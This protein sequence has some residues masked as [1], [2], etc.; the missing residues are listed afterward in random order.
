MYSQLCNFDGLGTTNI[1]SGYITTSLGGTSD[2]L[3]STWYGLG[4]TWDVLGVHGAGDGL[5]GG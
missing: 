3:G 1:V 5:S 4:G 2:C